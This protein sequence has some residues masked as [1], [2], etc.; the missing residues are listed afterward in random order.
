MA[1]QGRAGQARALVSP[2]LVQMFK[3]P[4][5][6][7]DGGSAVASASTNGLFLASIDMNR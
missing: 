7:E 3:P 2:A 5:V 6:F 1:R 4:T